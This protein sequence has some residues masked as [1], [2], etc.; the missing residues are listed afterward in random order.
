[1]IKICATPICTF[2]QGALLAEQARIDHL[3]SRFRPGG[4]RF[5]SS[6]FLILVMVLGA[7]ALIVGALAF[8]FHL[9]ERRGF[10]SPRRLFGELFS[11][12]ADRFLDEF[13]IGA[14]RPNAGVHVPF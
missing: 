1:M 7:I 3:G 9:K 5:D 12:R 14:D 11:S 10:N 2:Q 8:F 6:D 4:A 13:G